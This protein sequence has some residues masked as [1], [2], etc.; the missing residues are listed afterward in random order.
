[1]QPGLTTTGLAFLHIPLEIWDVWDK[2]NNPNPFPSLPLF[3][4]S[5]LNIDFMPGSGL[6]AGQK[7]CTGEEV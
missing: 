3:N 7:Q 4:E 1:M 6:Y 5:V 2:H